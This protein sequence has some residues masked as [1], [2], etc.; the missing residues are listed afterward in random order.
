MSINRNRNLTRPRKPDVDPLLGR[1]VDLLRA[2]PRSR[3]AKAYVSGLSPVTL[4]NWETGR[5]R[6]PQAVSLQMAARML[7]YKL[8]F[9]PNGKSK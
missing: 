9:V 6:R 1:M 4:K 8:D 7:G 3:H 5:V 2:D